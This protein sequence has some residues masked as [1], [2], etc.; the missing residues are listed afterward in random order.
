MRIG[1]K[2]RAVRAEVDRLVEE[3]GAML[4]GQLCQR[5][6]PGEASACVRVNELAHADWDRLTG[7]ADGRDPLRRS[8]WDGATRF[9]AAEMVSV[10]GHPEGLLRLQRSCLIPLELDMLAGGPTPASP[11]QLVQVVRDRL[12]R[13]RRR[14]THPS[15]S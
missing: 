11:T 4:A 10:A 13:S 1:R 2:E 3:A 12:A 6:D 9:L 8:A 15:A 5:C 7:I 14:P